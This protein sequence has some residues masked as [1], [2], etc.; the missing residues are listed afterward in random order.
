[1][2][3]LMEVDE[4]WGSSGGESS[5]GAC[6]RGNGSVTAYLTCP[7]STRPLMFRITTSKVHVRLI[8]R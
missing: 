4:G 3:V 5:I 7:P 1:M 2:I 8:C 6:W